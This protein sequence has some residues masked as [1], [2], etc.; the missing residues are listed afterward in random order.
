MN[1]PHTRAGQPNSTLLTNVQAERAVIADLIRDPDPQHVIRLG[2]HVDLFT[3]AAPRAAFTAITVFLTDGIKPD[4]ATLRAVLDEATLIEVET[5]LKEHVSAANLAVHVTLLKACWRNRRVQEE[6]NRLAKAVAAGCPEQELQAILESIK[7]APAGGE[8]NPAIPPPFRRFTESNLTEA[9]LHPKCIVE[10][11]LYA[12]LALVCAAGGTGKT[13]TLIYE[14]LCIAI[15]RDLWGCRVMN[16]GATLFITA[17]DSSDLFAARLREIM[18]VMGLSDYERRRALDRMAVWDV[19]GALVRLA[20]LEQGGN[21]RLTGLADQIVDA[22]RESHLA[23][24][25]FDPAISFGPGERVVNDGEQSVVVACRRIVRG[26]KCCVRLIHHTG[27]VNARAGTLDQY[28]SRGGTALP[29]GCR[30]VAVM[31]SVTEAT[32]NPPEGFDLAPGDSGFILARAKLSYA[33]P[34]P[35][36]WIRRRGFVFDWFAEE[37]VGKDETLTRDAAKVEQFIGDELMHGRKHTANTL[38]P[39]TGDKLKL[40]RRRLRAALAELETS[41]RVVLRDLPAEERRGVRKAYLHPRAYSAATDGGIDPENALAAGAPEPIPPPAII[42]PPY[43]ECRD[44]GIDA[45]L[46]CSPSLNSSASDGGIAA[47]WRNSD[48]APESP[49]VDNFSSP[50]AVRILAIL[51]ACPNGLARRDLANA[52][53]SSE[54]MVKWTCNRLMMAGQVAWRDG[55]YVAV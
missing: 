22:Y 44:G 27:K 18:A 13:T 23:Q 5:Y 1:T 26:L 4:A 36:L 30:M 49:P 48:E 10:H 43:R 9:R 17:E 55:R 29:D 37:R 34:Q 45:A 42:P 2:I 39:L 6:R 33:P 52:A 50:L 14:A 28:A 40:T 32:Q 53:G 20:E 51:D 21:I 24:V 35:N 12:D 38:D 54:A 3:R 46:H 31:S 7:Q 8:L 25:V 47:E 15:G 16:P 19:S 11:Y 41:E